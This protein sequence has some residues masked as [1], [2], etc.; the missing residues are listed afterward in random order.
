MTSQRDPCIG[1]LGVTLS[2]MT[3]GY[4]NG[5]LTSSV[6]QF[7]KNNVAEVTWN[8]IADSE[9]DKLPLYSPALLY[10]AHTSVQ[11]AAFKEF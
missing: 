7:S 8:N 9:G 2:V 5:G 6:E 11:L 4:C 1:S 10:T 3:R